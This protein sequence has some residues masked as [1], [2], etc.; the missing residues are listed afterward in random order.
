MGGTSLNEDAIADMVNFQERADTRAE[1]LCGVSHQHFNTVTTTNQKAM[2]RAVNV[3]AGPIDGDRFRIVHCFRPIVDRQSVK[4]ELS[5]GADQMR[6]A[7]DI[8][9]SDGSCCFIQCSDKTRLERRRNDFDNLIFGAP[10]GA[11]VRNCHTIVE[12]HIR[13]ERKQ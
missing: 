9:H 6:G 11:G 12:R 10:R 5:V 3:I 8:S 1:S 7:R 4:G 13:I 2:R